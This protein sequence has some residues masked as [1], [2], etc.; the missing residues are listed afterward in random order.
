MLRHY[1]YF[2]IGKFESNS[3]LEKDV[4]R[5]LRATW[6]PEE[7][8]YNLL[9]LIN[10]PNSRLHHFMKEEKGDVGCNS[11]E[12]SL[13]TLVLVSHLRSRVKLPSRN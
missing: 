10:F 9:I 3:I 5:I 7:N 4:N 8:E 6:E 11:M 13:Q 12:F 2:G 1:Y